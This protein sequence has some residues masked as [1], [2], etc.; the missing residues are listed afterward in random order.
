LGSKNPYIKGGTGAGVGALMGLGLGGTTGAAVGGLLGL[1]LPFAPALGIEAVKN[2]AN[3]ASEKVRGKPLF[4]QNPNANPVN[5]AVAQDML[6]GVDAKAAL[7]V[8]QAGER[9]GLNLRPA[10]ASGSPLAAAAEG[11]LGTTK[12]G[13]QSMYAFS[14]A[15]KQKQQKSITN[16]LDE[17]E[18]TGQP[19]AA[20]VRGAAKGLFKQESELLQKA[21]KPYYDK[22]YEKSIPEDTLNM[23]LQDPVINRSFG[24]ISKIPEYQKDLVGAAPNSLQYLNVVKKHIDDLNGAAVRKGKANISRI[25]TD[26][27]NRLKDELVAVSDDYKNALYIYGEGS[28]RLQKLKESPLGR[29]ANLKD[30]DLKSVSRIIFDPAETNPKVLAQLRD[31]ITQVNPDAWRGILRNHLENGLDRVGG[32]SAGGS[33][34]YNKFLKNDRS[35]NQLLT[36][37]KNIKGTTQKLIDMRRAFKDLINFEGVKTAAFQARKNIDNPRNDLSSYAQLAK[38]AL[39][40]KYDEAA[41]EF[42]QSGKWDKEFKTIMQNK[43]PN[44]RAAKFVSLLSRI[45]AEQATNPRGQFEEDE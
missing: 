28:G 9:L 7:K 20:N 14:Q 15:Q 4:T 17:I 37:S 29:L 38:N 36:A 8:K 6:T 44:A 5:A 42:V 21:A 13:A 39:G 12:K 26:S 40:S 25:L 19:A 34:F 32:P 43:E 23:L 30:K 2:L 10:E 16:L 45:A 11:N 3:K 18:G 35:F 22:A 41:I 1:G 33:A 24:R 31:K 27:K